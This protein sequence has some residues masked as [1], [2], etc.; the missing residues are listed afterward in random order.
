MNIVCDIF[1]YFVDVPS[2]PKG[3]LLISDVKENSCHLKWKPSEKDGGKPIEKYIIEVRE[4][5]RSM[6]STAGTVDDTTT[7]FTAKSLVVDNEYNFRVK[8]VNEEGESVPLEAD[9]TARPKKKIGNVTL[10]KYL[11]PEFFLFAYLQTLLL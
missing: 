7:D 1:I 10:Q 4:S 6:W 9:D 3:P 8:A 2:A 5:R 11:S